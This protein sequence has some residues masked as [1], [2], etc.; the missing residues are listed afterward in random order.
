M[1]MQ[2]T[3]SLASSWNKPEG[4]PGFRLPRGDGGSSVTSELQFIV[5]LWP[6]LLS[7]LP[8]HRWWL[9]ECLLI[10]PQ[11]TH[12]YIRVCFLENSSYMCRCQEDSNKAYSNMGFWSWM[13]CHQLVIKRPLADCRWS[14]EGLWHIISM[15]MSKLPPVMNWDIT[16]V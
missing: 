2:R 16:L 14:T 6:T 7:F 13:T 5:S 1:P 10:T 11:E 4:L 12:L 3:N 15:Q 9:H 8:L